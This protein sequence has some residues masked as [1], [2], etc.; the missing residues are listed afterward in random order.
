[1]ARVT[2][3]I[4]EEALRHAVSYAEGMEAAL[5]AETE[6]ISGRANSMG[7]G[8]RT[9]LYY[10]RHGQ[11]KPGVGNK[12]PI[13]KGDVRMGNH[14]YVGLVRSAN[15]AAMKDNYLHNTLLKAGGQ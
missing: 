12:Q 11:P 5:S 8:F 13:Y 15:Y 9:G 7:A 14:G 2:V 3:V 6:A 10:I 4:D 1:M